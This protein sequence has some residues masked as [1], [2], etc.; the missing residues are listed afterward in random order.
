MS[1]EEIDVNQRDRGHLF[2]LGEKSPPLIQPQGTSENK[3]TLF[4][5]IPLAY[6]SY[7]I[8]QNQDKMPVPPPEDFA[9]DKTRV[10]GFPTIRMTYHA[11]YRVAKPE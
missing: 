10:S 1:E 2:I 3:I 4:L 11:F 9:Y 5:Q 7:L 8:L 6:E